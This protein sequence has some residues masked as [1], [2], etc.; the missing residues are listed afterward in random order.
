M[1]RKTPSERFTVP[2]LSTRL[3]VMLVAF[4]LV[5]GLAPIGVAVATKPVPAEAGPIRIDIAAIESD[6]ASLRY[7][8]NYLARHRTWRAWSPRLADVSSRFNSIEA[9]LMGQARTAVA[10]YEAAS[11]T[12]ARGH[13]YVSA[14]RV[15]DSFIS[16]MDAAIDN[17]RRTG[18]LAMRPFG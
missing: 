4:A 15:L 7:Q 3:R 13:R 11:L 16:R 12:R 18:V 6:T 8:R 14:I 1:G 5:A 9:Q 10:S 17:Y 2:H